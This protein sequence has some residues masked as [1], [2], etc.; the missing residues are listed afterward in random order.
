VLT[1]KIPDWPGSFTVTAIHYAS[2]RRDRKIIMLA[3][4]Q[5]LESVRNKV[6]ISKESAGGLPAESAGGKNPPAGANLA[7]GSESE[8][9]AD[10]LHTAASGS[11]DAIM[12]CNHGLQ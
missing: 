9:S 4:Y 7:S 5:L 2:D 8:A 3:G 10:S 6:G 12:G 1:I 11:F